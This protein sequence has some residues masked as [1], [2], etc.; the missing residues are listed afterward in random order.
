MS[1][2]CGM[3]GSLLINLKLMH[4]F[5]TFGKVSCKPQRKSNKTVCN[6]SGSFLIPSVVVSHYIEMFMTRMPITETIVVK[7]LSTNEHKG[8][9]NGHL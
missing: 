8:R 7:Q 5:V 4:G 1:N 9:A 6:L 2:C 3:D